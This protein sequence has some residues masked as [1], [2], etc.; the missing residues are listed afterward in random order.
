MNYDEEILK[1]I[2]S[3]SEYLQNRKKASRRAL[4][5]G[6]G[7][8]LVVIL[9]TGIGLEITVNRFDSFGNISSVEEDWDW[10]D[11]SKTMMNG[12]LDRG[13]TIALFLQEMSPNYVPG[14]IRLGELYAMTGDLDKARLEFKKACDILPTERN[15][16]YLQA[17]D[18]R[19][20][21]ALS[22]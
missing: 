22:Q 11:V 18:K 1:E 8:Y 2:R 19:L 13:I 17:I 3:I 7:I 9:A 12:D 4:W 10:H 20:K 16:D 15:L 5:I 14:H 21:A 6:L